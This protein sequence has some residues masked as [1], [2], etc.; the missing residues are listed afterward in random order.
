MVWILAWDSKKILLS[1]DWAIG[2][3]DLTC[4]KLFLY[5]LCTEVVL[6][7]TVYSKKKKVNQSQVANFCIVLSK[8][9]KILW[10]EPRAFFLILLFCSI[11]FHFQTHT[12]N[13]KD[14]TKPIECS[15]AHL[16]PTC[17]FPVSLLFVQQHKRLSGKPF[18]FGTLLYS[19]PPPTG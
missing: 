8:S 13:H 12:H 16:C 5:F 15:G 4:F 18:V 3:S 10:I 19:T 6:R 9:P 1:R 2:S 7:K 11:C 14:N 17:I